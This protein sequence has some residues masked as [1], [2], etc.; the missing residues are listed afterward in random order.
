[1]KWQLR[2]QGLRCRRDVDL[3]M[4]CRWKMHSIGIDRLDEDGKE[5]IWRNGDLSGQMTLW[6]LVEIVEE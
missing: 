1:M 6:S 2:L 3:H 4:N 5:M